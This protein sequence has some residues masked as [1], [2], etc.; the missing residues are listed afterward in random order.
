[1]CWELNMG[2]NTLLEILVLICMSWELDLSQNI[3]LVL[4]VLIASHGIGTA[5]SDIIYKEYKLCD[6]NSI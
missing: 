1:M 4:Q 5:H 2:Q 3:L 6:I